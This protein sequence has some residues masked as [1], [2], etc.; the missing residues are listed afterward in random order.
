M[1]LSSREPKRIRHIELSEKNKVLRLVLIVILLAVGAA[2]LAAGLTSLLNVEPGW[3]EIESNSKKPNCSNEFVFHYDFTESG[4]G[5]TAQYK[6]I[7]QLYT[8]ATEKAY[9]VFSSDV[10]VDGLYNVQYINGHI[11]EEITVDETLYNALELVQRYNC[12]YLYLAPVY[13]EY[14]RIFTAESEQIA[15]GFDPAQNVELIPYISEIASMANDPQMIDLELLGE[16]RI[17]LSVSDEYLEYAREYEIDEFIDF[18]WMKNAFIADYITDIMC[19][20]GFT[21]GYIASYDGFTR[22]MDDR[23]IS[24][25][26]NIFNREG[27]AID[28]PAVMHYSQPTSIVFMRNYPMSELD[29]WHY[30]VFSSG[31]TASAYIDASDGLYKSAV[32]NLVSYSSELGCAEIMLQMSP[33][34]IAE[35]FDEAMISK[36]SENAVYSVWIEDH[37]IRYNDEKLNLDLMNDGTNYSK[38]FA[39]K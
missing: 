17:K 23:G 2:A 10:S 37:T 36:M 16:N 27:N 28:M 32:D 19:S 3:Q 18:G 11:N 7:V 29:K 22:N 8:E 5:S 21:R 15:A 34:Y 26:F 30:Y 9:E 39:G 31:E 12:R 13:V 1:S 35:M 24:Y 6:Q 33:V 20:N 38:V 4:A 14:N 25:T